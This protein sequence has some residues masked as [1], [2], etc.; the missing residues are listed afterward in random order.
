MQ[1]IKSMTSE[2]LKNY[3]ISLGEPPFKAKQIFKWLNR[4]VRTFE[5]MTDISKDLKAKLNENAYIN[6]LEIERKLVS[7]IDGTVKYLFKLMDGEHVESVVMKYKHGNSICISAQVGCKMGCSFCASTIG[8][9]KRNLTAAEILDQVMFAG[10]D[11][12]EKISN[13]VLMGIGEPLDNF[14]NV[15]DFIDNVNNENGLNIG[16][17]HI[18]LSTCGIVDKIME[19]AD[20]GLQITLSI[21]LHAPNDTIRK[22]IMPIN[23][24]WGVDELINSCHY[25]IAKTGRRISF[26]YTLIDGV[27]NSLECAEELARKLKGMICHLNIISVNPVKERAYKALSEMKTNEFCELLKKKG[28]NATVRRVLG[29]DINASCGQ[30]RRESSLSA[31]EEAKK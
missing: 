27:N 22:K 31:N 28:I 24:K 13:I 17:R 5:E 4:G 19:L 29:A 11:Y 16:Q 12:G 3:I 23:F 26:E 30:L 25:Y 18:S 9:F 7:E 20:K 21:S 8:G 14:N 6:T 1:D 2:K 15:L 10:L